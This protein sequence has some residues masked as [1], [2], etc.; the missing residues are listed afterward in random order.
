[1]LRHEHDTDGVS[2]RRHGCRA[3]GFFCLALLREDAPPREYPLRD[4]FYATLYVVETS[5]QWQ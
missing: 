3:G 1:M 4:F 2:K 5:C